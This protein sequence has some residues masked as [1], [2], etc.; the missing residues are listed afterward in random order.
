VHLIVVVQYAKVLFQLGDFILEVQQHAVVE[1]LEAPV[2]RGQAGLFA[3]RCRRAQ[4][5][6]QEAVSGGNMRGPG[7]P[8]GFPVRAMEIFLGTSWGRRGKRRS[9]KGLGITRRGVVRLRHG[10]KV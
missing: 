2:E 8:S 3:V 1:I 10:S 6:G 7:F 9:G 5:P 4:A